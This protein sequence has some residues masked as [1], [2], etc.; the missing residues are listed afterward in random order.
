MEPMFPGGNV[1]L[2]FYKQDILSKIKKSPKEEAQKTRV[3][4]MV[5]FNDLGKVEQCNSD[6]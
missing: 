3:E 1:Q 6:K 2:E 4:V 5:T